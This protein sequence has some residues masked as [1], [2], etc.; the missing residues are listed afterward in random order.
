MKTEN[1]FQRDLIKRLRLV[2]PESV[3]L[4]NDSSYLQGV[5]DLLLLVGNKWAALECKK[6]KSA[7]HRPNQDYYIDK[8]NGM[9]FAA[10]VYPENLEEVI[11]ELQQTLGT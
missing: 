10:F 8:M 3:I 1:K 5:P 6:T 4:K 7:G 11:Y 2:F 9:S